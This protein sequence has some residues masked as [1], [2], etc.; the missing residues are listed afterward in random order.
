MNPIAALI[1]SIQEG[2]AVSVSMLFDKLMAQKLSEAIE[3][4]KVE[5]AESIFEK[6]ESFEVFE[7]DEDFDPDQLDESAGSLSGLPPHVI[8][9]LTKT[10][11][12]G[13]NS[14]IAKHQAK[15]VSSLAGHVK[16]GLAKGHAVAIHVNGKLHKVVSSKHDSNW[17]REHFTVHD[18]EKQ[19]SVKERKMIDKGRSIRKSDGSYRH[20]PPRYNEYDRKDFT[21]SEA[22]DHAT[23][24]M[25]EGSHEKEFYKNNHVEVHHIPVDKER[26]KKSAE[27]KA[28]RPNMQYNYVKAKE[29][30]KEHY[31]TNNKH[32]SNTPAG[33]NLEGVKKA[34]ALKLAKKK[35]G[36][37]GNDAKSKAMEIHRE[38]AKHIEA[39]DH[40]AVKSS[41]EKLHHHVQNVGLQSQDDKVKEYAKELPKLK[42]HHDKEYTKKRLAGMRGETNE[43][44]EDEISKLF[45]LVIE[46]YS[47][48]K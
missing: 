12:A 8:K 30:E 41:L 22:L 21:K 25:G 40:K 16:D 45:D 42:S 5:I 1:E 15:S 20:I 13:E 46:D 11:G 6:K 35:L 31:Y 48:L 27:R 37:A 19:A 32:T 14:E 18:S 10:Q 29:G 24:G 7:F 4:K 17:G 44:I 3:D 38:L 9:H 34:A 36:D 23:R 28:N 33:D 43:S 39:G 26:A 47:N 2:D